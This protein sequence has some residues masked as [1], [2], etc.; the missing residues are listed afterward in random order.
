MAEGSASRRSSYLVLQGLH[1]WWMCS[2]KVPFGQGLQEPKHRAGLVSVPIP[3]NSRQWLVETHG[4]RWAPGLCRT[5]QCKSCT[6]RC[7]TRTLL[8]SR[9]LCQ[10]RGCI[11]S[12]RP[13][14]LDAG[15]K[16]GGSV[17]KSDVDRGNAVSLIASSALPTHCVHGTHS[18]FMGPFVYMLG[19]HGVQRSRGWGPHNLSKR[20]PV[21]SKRDACHFFFFF[22]SHSQ[23]REMCE[24]TARK[25]VLKRAAA[26]SKRICRALLNMQ[27]ILTS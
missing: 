12:A 15:R 25:A 11:P 27:I 19:L 23:A 22:L 10:T 6:C 26:E 14:L 1:F 2:L 9:T 8:C 21:T 4:S 18:W 3:D 16:G 20:F 24:S 5:S 7:H 17:I 13:E